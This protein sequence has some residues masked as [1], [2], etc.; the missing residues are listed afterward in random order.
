MGAEDASLTGLPREGCARNSPPPYGG[1]VAIANYDSALPSRV[2]P[3]PL[4]G[5]EVASLTGLR[6]SPL[7][8]G[9]I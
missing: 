4:R 7:R 6:A 8:G 2:L 5:V 3:S 1:R 9:A